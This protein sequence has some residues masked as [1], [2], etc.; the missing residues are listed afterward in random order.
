MATR[1]DCPK[2]GHGRV[3]DG[4]RLTCSDKACRCA[5]CHRTFSEQERKEWA[6]Q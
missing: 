5:D 1:T 2:D 3:L 4:N 6:R